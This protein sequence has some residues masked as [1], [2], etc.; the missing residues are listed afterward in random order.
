LRG[1]GKA[2]LVCPASSPRRTAAS[3][4][5]IARKMPS[6]PAKRGVRRAAEFADNPRH[7]K[8]VLA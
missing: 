5:D 8:L 3:R 4:F 7:G 6:A 1:N 2:A